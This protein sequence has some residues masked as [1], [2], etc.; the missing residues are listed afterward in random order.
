MLSLV[1][2]KVNGAQSLDEQKCKQHFMKILSC[3]CLQVTDIAIHKSSHLALQEATHM[4]LFMFSALCSSRFYK[5]TCTGVNAVAVA[6]IT[7]YNL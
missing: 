1:N 3:D 4:A 7:S 2:Q 5:C 6:C